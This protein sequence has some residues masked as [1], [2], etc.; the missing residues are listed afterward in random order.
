MG[1]TEITRIIGGNM[2]T[3]KDKDFYPTPTWVTEELLSH[4]DIE[5]DILEPA[6]GNGAISKV[7][8]KYGH[9]VQS[10]D[11]Y[12][13]G[14]G[15]PNIDFMKY[16]EPV[17]NIITNPP[18]NLSTKFAIHGLNLVRRKLIFFNKLT[19]LEGKTR[20]S[21]LFDLRKLEKVIVFSERVNFD[22]SSGQRTGGMMSF[23]WFIFNKNYEG[24]PF[25]E[26]V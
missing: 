23:A 16:M 17:D 8:E 7:L 9:K 18:F 6:C 15:T 22:I 12:D 24:H 11:L 2:G 25:L 4:V 26:W 21:Q 13:Y 20:K 19:F 14:Y 3:R 5:G 10:Q 1:V